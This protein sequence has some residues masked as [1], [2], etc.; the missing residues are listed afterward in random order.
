MEKK[1]KFPRPTTPPGPNGP[2]IRTVAGITYMWTPNPTVKN[3]GYWRSVP[4]HL[5]R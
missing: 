5:Q 2:W 1:I 3:K 4:K